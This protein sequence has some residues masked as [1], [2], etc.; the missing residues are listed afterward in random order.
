MAHIFT[1]YTPHPTY[2][3]SQPNNYRVPPNCRFD[4][5]DMERPWMWQE[6]SFDFIFSRDLLLSIRDFPKLIDQCYTSV[7]PSSPSYT[8]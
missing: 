3:T 7:S 4:L 8:K 6:N 2:R 5:D 1:Y